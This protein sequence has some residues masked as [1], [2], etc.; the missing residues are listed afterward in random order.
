[1][2]NRSRI[3][4]FGRGVTLVELLV[5]VTIMVLLLGVALPLVQPAL[6]GRELR[7]ASRQVSTFIMSAQARAISKGKIVGVAFVRDPANTNRAFQ[8]R[9]AET[10]SGYM[11][12]L[13]T[14]KS[15]IVNIDSNND[16]VPEFGRAFIGNSTPGATDHLTAAASV[17]RILQTGQ[18]ATIQFDH[19]ARTFSLV[20]HPAPPDEPPIDPIQI[21]PASDTPTGLVQWSI[22]FFPPHPSPSPTLWRTFKV[23]RPPKF[24]SDEPLELPTDTCVDLSLSGMGR[25]G[26]I[27]SD[28]F[29]NAD[30]DDPQSLTDLGVNYFMFTF[31]TDGS[32]R[33]TFAPWDDH[34]DNSPESIRRCPNGTPSCPVPQTLHFLIGRPNG[35]ASARNDKFDADGGMNITSDELEDLGKT[36]KLAD[37]LEDELEGNLEAADSFWISVNHRTGRVST[38][39]NQGVD[40]VLAEFRSGA[41]TDLYLPKAVASARAFAASRVGIG[42]R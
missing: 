29:P 38:T 40:D 27:P 22:D 6:K 10:P 5:V 39:S 33:D 8:L 41:T 14:S 12:E 32:I 1:V 7:E 30:E 19:R 31:D 16:G 25:F 37:F 21:R 42:G 26:T 11:G 18:G 4:R 15:L 35:V 23:L 2:N 24:T 17:D 13:E 34:F 20:T 28:M 36:D 9:L 3:R